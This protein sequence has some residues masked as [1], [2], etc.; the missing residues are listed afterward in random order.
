MRMATT[1]GITP[2]DICMHYL[3]KEVWYLFLLKRY[4]F[5]FLKGHESL[6]ATYIK[7]E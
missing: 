2:L 4:E 3:A 1:H 7:Y 5:H 6:L